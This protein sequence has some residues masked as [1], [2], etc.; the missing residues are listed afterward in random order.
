MIIE[1][2]QQVES[3]LENHGVTFTATLVG[4]QTRDGW[5]CDAWNV[6]F[7]RGDVSERFD[8][9]TGTGH[10]KANDSAMAKRSAHALRN[11]SKRMLAWKEHYKR[12]PDKPVAPHPAD[13]LQSLIL[14]ASVVGQSFASWCSDYGYDTDSRKA[15]AIYEACQ[16]NAD[17][18]ARVFDGAAREALEVALRDY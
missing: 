10:R 8:Y 13:V 11:V 9:F 7:V 16:A 18:F 6:S 2:K 14:D 12:Y 1:A 3:I 17:K 5:E 4:P 15:F